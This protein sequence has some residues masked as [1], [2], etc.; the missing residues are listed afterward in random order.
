LFISQPVWI[1]SLVL[2]SIAVLLP[3]ICAVFVI[4]QRNNQ[5]VSV[6]Q[7]IFLLLLCFGA[8]LS[9]CPIFIM[10]LDSAPE[11]YAHLLNADSACIATL[12]L[13]Y[14]GIIVTYLSLVCKLYRAYEVTKFKKGQRVLARHV[15]WP[16]VVSLAI[17]AGLLTAWTVSAPPTY[18][19]GCFDCPNDDW[20]D[21]VSDGGAFIFS[22]TGTPTTTNLED[23]ER[24]YGYC[25]W[26]PDYKLILSSLALFSSF[27]AMWMSWRTRKIREDVSDSR[28]V[29]QVM[30]F[31]FVLFILS[32]TESFANKH[33]F[34]VYVLTPIV[35]QFLLAVSVVS[36]L[37]FPK[38]YY[39]WYQDQH[40]RLPDG[41]RRLSGVVKI[42]GVT[43]PTESNSVF[44]DETS[45]ISS[46]ERDVTSAFNISDASMQHATA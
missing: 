1:F 33:Q 40:G 45:G 38:M 18:E 30:C 23:E 37:I 46:H 26:N 31:H 19:L 13:I 25:S 44:P 5:I 2:A 32:I 28:R 10:A 16:L 20:K 8:V 14:L 24:I 36:I 41:L 21:E 3:I 42:S 9:G 22:Q 6:G 12:W 43:E 34:T 4:W 11:E 35:N 39:C 17:M 7:P 29:F 27:L 15:I